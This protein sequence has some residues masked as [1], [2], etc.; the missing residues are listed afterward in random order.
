MTMKGTLVWRTRIVAQALLAIPDAPPACFAHRARQASVPKP[1]QGTLSLDPSSLRGG[2]NQLRLPLWGRWIAKGETD[3]V[4]ARRQSS[5]A[6]SL[7][8]IQ[9][10]PRIIDSLIRGVLFLFSYQPTSAIG[11]AVSA[12]SLVTLIDE[13]I[14]CTAASICAAP[15]AC[16]YTAVNTSVSPASTTASV[17]SS[18]SCPSS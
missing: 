1:L 11:S 7:L 10:T 18:A 5:L 9:E 14:A 4:P 6:K 13:S 16:G 8:Y 15:S 17:T 2:F 3:E 12:P